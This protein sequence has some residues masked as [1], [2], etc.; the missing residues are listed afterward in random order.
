[1]NRTA[2]LFSVSALALGGML[3]AAPAAQAAPRH[4]CGSISQVNG[5]NNNGILNGTQIA[6]PVNIDLDISH[7]ALGLLGSASSSGDDIN[8]CGTPGG[9]IG[10]PHAGRPS[11]VRVVRL[12][13]GRTLVTY[14]VIRHH[15]LQLVTVIYRRR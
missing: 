9:G 3:L 6:V 11:V 10:W 14:R 8:Y 15:R 12:P 1:M 2:R 4:Y 5:N 13:G 7:N